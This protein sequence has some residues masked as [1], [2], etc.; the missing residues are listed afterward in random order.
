MGKKVILIQGA[1]DFE[2]NY[3]ILTKIRFIK[4]L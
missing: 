3:K 4:E 2:T 1:L